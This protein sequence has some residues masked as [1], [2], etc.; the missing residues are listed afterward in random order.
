M[1]KEFPVSV[2]N[3]RIQFNSGSVEVSFQR[4][5]R[6]PVSE[7]GSSDAVYDLPAGLGRFP[8]RRVEAY[9]GFLPSDWVERGGVVI[10]MHYLEAMWI[11][12]SAGYGHAVKVGVGN[13]NAI[14]GKEFSLKLISDEEDDMFDYCVVPK[15][16]WIDGIK[17]GDGEVRQFV[18]TRMGDG[19]SVEAQVTGEEKYGGVQLAVFKAKPEHKSRVDNSFNTRG[20]ITLES[21]MG[22]VASKSVM[23]FVG[24]KTRSVSNQASSAGG[25]SLGGMED[26]MSIGAGA[27]ILQKIYPDPY[28]IETWDQE[29]PL[30]CFINIVSAYD[31]YRM[32]GE[33]ITTPITPAVYESRGIPMYKYMKDQYNKDVAA[34]DALKKVKSV[35]QTT[36]ES[37]GVIPE[38]KFKPT[39]SIDVGPKKPSENKNPTTGPVSQR[40][41]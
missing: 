39:D 1:S 37:G 7:D 35:G 13:V 36:A 9:E 14:S 17:T 15:Q 29:S 33:E 26:A 30:R 16:P 6:L 21:A 27:K 2:I 24:V 41:W 28:G 4:T 19:Q 32:T 22:G 12:F 20:G 3:D 18:A 40:G 34:W 11:S 31:W 5:L 8:I 23:N 10:P 38:N 25:Q